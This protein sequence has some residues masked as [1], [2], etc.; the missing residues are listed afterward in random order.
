MILELENRVNREIITGYENV[1]VSA[2]EAEPVENRVRLK[3][4]L[5]AQYVV[6][7]QMMLELV[8]AQEA[9]E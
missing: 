6:W 3:C 4:G 1:A 5:V 9:A 7:D 8:E 2:L